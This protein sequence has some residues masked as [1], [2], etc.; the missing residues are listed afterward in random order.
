[1]IATFSWNLTLS[2]TK[3]TNLFSLPLSIL[4]AYKRHPFQV[5]PPGIAHYRESPR[6]RGGGG[7][8]LCQA[9]TLCLQVIFIYG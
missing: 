2:Y 8:T 5:E 4:Q 7:L 9:K 1:M 3:M 6:G